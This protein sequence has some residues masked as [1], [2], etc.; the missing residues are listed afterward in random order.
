VRAKRILVICASL[1]LALL[2]GPAWCGQD[3][4]SANAIM[5]G[6]R[7]VEKPSPSFSS[8]A[9]AGYC[10]GTVYGVAF[11]AGWRSVDLNVLPPLLYS[12]RGYWVSNGPRRGP[13][14]RPAATEDARA[15][16]EAR[17]RGPESS[18]AL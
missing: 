5:S 10:L 2:T 3:Y 1:A 7:T 11:G 12:R 4:K 17:L 9:E 8:A 6:C 13:V 14:H 15:V 16:Y 18:M